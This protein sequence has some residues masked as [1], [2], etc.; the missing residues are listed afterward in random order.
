MNYA[1]EDFLSNWN[2]SFD[3]TDIKA[4][5]MQVYIYTRNAKMQTSKY[6]HLSFRMQKG[7]ALESVYIHLYVYIHN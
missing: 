1:R 5:Y 6:I 4:K 7:T 2:F 3:N